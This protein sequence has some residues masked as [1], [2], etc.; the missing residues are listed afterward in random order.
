MEY[1]KVLHLGTCGYVAVVERSLES[2]R[3]Q[4]TFRCVYADHLSLEAS[5]EASAYVGDRHRLEGTIRKKCSVDSVE[6]KHGEVKYF[7]LLFSASN[8]IRMNVCFKMK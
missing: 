7:I 1:Y 4:P 6:E 3:R 5:S 8:E 2:W